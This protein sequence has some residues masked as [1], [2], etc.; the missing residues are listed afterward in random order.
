MTT[1]SYIFCSLW[2]VEQSDGAEKATSK[3]KGKTI[4]RYPESTNSIDVRTASCSDPLY[5]L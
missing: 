1:P 5:K 4:K 3:K 2:I